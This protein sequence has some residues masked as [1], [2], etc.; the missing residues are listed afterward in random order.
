[1]FGFFKK[2]IISLIINRMVDK[3]LV[4]SVNHPKLKDIKQSTKNIF[5]SFGNNNLDK[6]FYVIRINYGGGIFSILLYVL[7]Q[8]RVAESMNAI[9]VIDMEN[10]STKYNELN[11]IKKTFNSWDYYFEPISKYSLKEVYSS[12][13]VIINTGAPTDE[14]PKNWKQDPEIFN[15]Y[16][17]KYIKIKK[18]FIRA[19]DIFS[20]KHFHNNR[21]LGVHFR[22]KGMYNTPNHPFTPT[23]TQITNKVDEYLR[24]KKFDKIFLVTAQ[25]N[26]LEIFKKKYGEKLCYCDSFRVNTTRAFHYHDARLNHRYKMGRDIIVEM[27]LLSKL[28][29]LICSRS[30]VS[31]LATLISGNKDY[32]VFEIWNG[33][34]TKKIILGLFLWDI[35]RLLPEF[36][37]GFKRNI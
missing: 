7:S 34:N 11:K 37:G 2:K 5:K 14:A 20:K 15:L 8:I 19:S 6:T 17:K 23:P 18:E 33:M 4:R 13:F 28:S 16:F 36:L 31:E 29:T 1:M 21:V 3:P 9:P 35:K 30:N 32:E 10:F 27:L 24:E 22:G 25:K 12:K 26:Y